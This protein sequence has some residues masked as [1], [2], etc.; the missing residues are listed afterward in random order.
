AKLVGNNAS[1]FAS[2]GQSVALSADGNIAIVGG[3]FDNGQAG[4]VWVFTRSGG[5]WSQQ[6]KLFA[7]DATGNARQGTSVAL[8][9]DG[10]TAIVGG[11]CD[12]PGGCS[13]GGVGAAWVFTHSGGG[14]RQ[15]GIKLVASD[16]VGSAAQ[17]VSVAL[18]ADGNIALVGGPDDN[19]GAGAA[20]VYTRSGTVW[21]QQG[22]KLVGT[23][24]S[25]TALQG[26]SVALFCNAAIVGGPDD[27][28]QA[29]AGAAWMFVRPATA[30]HD[31]GCD[32]VSDI[33]WWNSTTGQT[34]IWLMNGSSIVGGGSPGSAPTEWAIVGQRDF[35][36]D[37]YADIVWRNGSTGQA[38]LWFLNGTSLI[39]EG[40]P[41]SAASP[42]TIAGTGDFN[43]DRFGDLLWYN[44]ST[45]QAVIWLMNG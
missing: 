29:G 16:A 32:G 19:S 5:G 7:T 6:A 38:L 28:N 9:A 45:G 20:W 43:G 24:A 10:T 3:P 15:Q 4:A 30:T 41:G 1:A 11:P 17:G 34:V 36:R 33:L 44:T 42:W 25:A 40:S 14:W 22:S 35:N 31:F 21:T 18:S 37:G 27:I 23:S 39:G 26:F 12:N 8:S 2:Q 13:S